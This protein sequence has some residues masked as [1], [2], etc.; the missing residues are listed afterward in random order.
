MAGFNQQNLRSQG[1]YGSHFNNII[2]TSIFDARMVSQTA[3]DHGVYPWLPLG[4]YPAGSRSFNYSKT[5]QAFSPGIEAKINANWQFTNAVGFSFGVTG[6]WV[7]EIARGS[8]INDYVITNDGQ[9]FRLK[10]KGFTD[11]AL[12]YGITFGVTVNRH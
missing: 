11:A 7:D 10:D 6:M 2:D 1:T 9:F 8:K 3:M 5:H 4:I 12:M